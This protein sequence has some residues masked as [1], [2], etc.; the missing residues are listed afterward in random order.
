MRKRA[1]SIRGSLI[2]E[3]MADITATASVGKKIQNGEFREH[4]IEPEWKCPDEFAMKKVPSPHFMMELLRPKEDEVHI[5]ILQLHGGGY[6]GPM[7]NIYRKFAVRYS[8]E[9]KGAAVLTIDYRVAPLHPYPAAL[10]DALA[11]Y[12]WIL[13]QGY[14]PEE[15]ILVGDSAGGGLA[16]CLCHYLKDNHR[17]LPSKIITMSA[18]TDLTLSGESYTTKYSEDP[19]FGNTTDSLL[20]RPDYAGE[21]DKTNPYISP[22]FGDFTGF[23]PM[24]MQVGT[25]EM[26]LSD[27]IRVAEKAKSQKVKVKLSVYEG[28][29]HVFQMAGSLIPESKQAWNEIRKF[30]KLTP[31]KTK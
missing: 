7:K 1:V 29:F 27:T 26:L 19:L 30:L 16:L 22:L 25:H 4:P 8:Q 13:D 9:A 23:P 6:I 10:D 14:L 12:D 5:M 31:K 17:P 18:W 28:M 11:A 15:I 20:F 21:H 2:R 24:L 3:L